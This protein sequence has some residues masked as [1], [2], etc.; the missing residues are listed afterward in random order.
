MSKYYTMVEINKLANNLIH[1]HEILD[2]TVKGIRKYGMDKK[3]VYEYSGPWPQSWNIEF[4]NIWSM[5][6]ALNREDYNRIIKC[7]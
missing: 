6:L 7:K 1:G 3:K 5:L 4:N 2:Y